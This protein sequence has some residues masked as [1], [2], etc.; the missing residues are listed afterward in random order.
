M[1]PW[2]GLGS[3]MRACCPRVF[4]AG[5][6]DVLAEMCLLEP[7]SVQ[8]KISTRICSHAT[9]MVPERRYV[10]AP[11][12]TVNVWPGSPVYNLNV[13][14]LNEGGAKTRIQ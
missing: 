3:D 13:R 6:W 11:T 2:W 12:K 5:N 10:H 8:S 1:I 7:W 4:H 14:N 9:V